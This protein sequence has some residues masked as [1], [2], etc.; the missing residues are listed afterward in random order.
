MS[1]LNGTLPNIR[2]VYDTYRYLL[3]FHVILLFTMSDDE[4]ELEVLDKQWQSGIILNLD[5]VSMVHNV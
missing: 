3:C 4:K 2:I 5:T 1:S